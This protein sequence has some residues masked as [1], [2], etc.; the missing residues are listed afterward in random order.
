M[1]VLAISLL[2]V[3]ILCLIPVALI[4]RNHLRH[5]EQMLADMAELA[6]EAIKE[7][8]PWQQ[9]AARQRYNALVDRQLAWTDR[10]ARYDE[11]EDR[12]RHA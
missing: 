4:G 6:D 10:T 1:Q 8:A 5:V 3:V 12:I 9:Q 11:D 2:I 7:L